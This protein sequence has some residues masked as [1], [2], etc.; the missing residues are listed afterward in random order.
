MT[1][2]GCLYSALNSLWV[3]QDSQGLIHLRPENKMDTVFLQAL[4]RTTRTKELSVLPW[5]EEQK[6]A[7]LNMQFD[8]Q[9][10]DYRLRYPD[11]EFLM[12]QNVNP[13][14][15]I[16]LHTV[17]QEVLVIDIALLPEY[18]SLGIGSQLIKN[19]QK[20]VATQGK[21]I[22]LHV[23]THNFRAQL[24]YYRLGFRFHAEQEF[25]LQLVWQSQCN[26]D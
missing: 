2:F 24:F 1:K 26:E 10:Q 16:Y 25:Y 19:I 3:E 18:R 13:I 5:S 21:S 23:A 17:A 9:R 4:Y 20:Y 6:L 11:A 15:R 12:I 7:F 8:M 22:R 14:G